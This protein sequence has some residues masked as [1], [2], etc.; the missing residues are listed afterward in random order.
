[1][2]KP[3]GKVIIKVIIVPGLEENGYRLREK[4]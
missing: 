4:I 3:Y 2:T 1:M